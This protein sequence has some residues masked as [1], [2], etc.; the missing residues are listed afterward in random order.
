MYYGITLL[1]NG[2]LIT[3]GNTLFF[4][5]TGSAVRTTSD[6]TNEF[7][8]GTITKQAISGS[9]SFPVGHSSGYTPLDIANASGG[10]DFTVLAQDGSGTG[11]DPNHSLAEFWT[12]SATGSVTL[13]LTFNYLPADVNGDESQY[14]IIRIENGTAV[15]FGLSVPGVSYDTVNHKATL[16]GVSQFSDWTLGESVT[17]TAVNLDHFTATATSGGTLL[18]WQTGF[19]VNNLGF[20]IYRQSGSE[21]VK[22]NPSLIAGT[23]LKVGSGVRVESGYEYIWQDNAVDANAGYWLED[24]DLNGDSTWHGPFGVI[25]STGT[26][27][28]RPLTGTKSVLLNDLNN[29]Q[30]TTN[31][32]REFPAG[33]NPVSPVFNVYGSVLPITN[34]RIPQ[35][36]TPIST[37]LKTQWMLASQ[38][39]LKI[40]INKP[41]WYHVKMSD[42]IAAGLNPNAS[43]QNLQMFVG[44]IEIPIIANADYVEFYAL[45]LDTPSTDTQIYW[46]TAGFQSGKRITEQQAIAS[47]SKNNSNSFLY[48]VERKDRTLYFSSLLNGDTENWFGSVITTQP[49]SETLSIQHL[50]Q[51]AVEQAQLEIALQGVTTNSHLV[52]VAFN[53]VVVGSINFDGMTH[54]TIKLSIPLGA[55]IEGN[56]QVALTSQTSG[57]VSLV[58]SV[59]VTYAHTYVADNNSLMLR[60]SM[61]PVKITGFSSNQIRAIDITNP[62]QQMELTGEVEQDGN[63]YSISIAAA[64][65]RNLVVMTPDRFMQPQSISAN[66]PSVLNSGSNGSDFVIITHRD[67]SAGI[68][69]LAALRQSQGYQ[70][71]VVDIEDIYDE[72]SY[73]VHTPYAVKDFLNWTYTRW[74]RQPQYVLLAGGGTL[75]PRNYTGVGYMD[76]VPTKLIDTGGMETA[77]DDW[78]VDFNNDGIPQMSIGRLPAFTATE[79]TN[80]VNKIIGYE[81]SGKATTAVLVSDISDNADFNTPNRQ[82]RSLIPPQMSVVNIVR[83]QTITDAKTALMNQLSQGQRIVNYEGHGSVNLW[84]GNLLTNDDVQTLANQKA[85]PLVVTM[86]CLNG[87]F[88]DR[89][90]RAWVSRLSRYRA[91]GQYQS[92]LRQQ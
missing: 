38:S 88:V 49:A 83:G 14:R 50:D 22:I 89:G 60:Q 62:N 74:Q 34:S 79:T 40:G 76:F 11:L 44:G 72:F 52:N 55:L 43:P 32:Q 41:G 37:A 66:Q 13:D 9:F 48:T 78:M 56:N 5:P 45:G 20:N 19:E 90:Y 27:S 63:Q 12:L 28:G 70:V 10:G 17:P 84:R 57:D 87:Y 71:A 26:A 2:V 16:T 18:Q 69:P 85:S 73:G 80:L 23:A 67:F 86:T 61:Q 36:P 59:R 64:K 68:Q 35:K 21:R 33:F 82:I 1:V 58:D 81:Q 3:N 30:Q 24:I 15:T 8:V 6:P 75:D 47:N 7:V 29:A 91:E 51:N 65:H 39:A 53:G 92:G 54:K 46:L 31:T 77:F 42:L 4:S 25:E